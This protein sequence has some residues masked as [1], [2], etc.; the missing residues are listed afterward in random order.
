VDVPKRS[1][2][3]D[4]C[5]FSRYPLARSRGAVARVVVH[6]LGEQKCLPGE[7]VP[8]TEPETTLTIPGHEKWPGL[9][10]ISVVYCFDGEVL[11]VTDPEAVGRGIQRLPAGAGP[12]TWS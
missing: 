9:R 5:T 1:V 10:G 12:E 3:G 4:A 6:R 8:V 7:A 2:R 11:V